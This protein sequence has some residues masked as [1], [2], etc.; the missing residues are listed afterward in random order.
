MKRIIL[1]MVLSLF[2]GCS[3]HTPEV[4]FWQW[5][6]ENESRLFDFEKDQERIFHD[7]GIALKK[8]HPDLT[9]EFGQKENGKREFVISA[10][11]LKSAFPAVESLYAAAPS[12]GRWSFIKFRQRQHP[13]YDID[14]GN[15]II[16][17]PDVHFRLAN[18]ENPNKIGILIFMPGYNEAE[19][20]VYDH[21][22]YLMLDEALGE[23]DVETKVGF[24]EIQGYD[25]EYFPGSLPLDELGSRFDEVMKNKK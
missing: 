5:F 20:K 12:L 25:S 6:Q 19:K 24:I 10:D 8:V 21:I 9:F 22:A 23:F 16:K 11:G 18:D 17:V 1:I 4:D 13:L 3:K 2:V 7:L 15:K 14:Y